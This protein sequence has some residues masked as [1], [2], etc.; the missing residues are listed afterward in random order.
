[1]GN[2]SGNLTFSAKGLG[3]GSYLL[4]GAPVQITVGVPN[5]ISSYQFDSIPDTLWLDT[6]NWTSFILPID[7]FPEWGHYILFEVGGNG[8]AML[9][10]IGISSCP[11]VNFSYEDGG[12]VCTTQSGYDAEYFLNLDDGDS[13]RTFHVLESPFILTDIAL[14]HTYTISWQCPYQN[15]GCLPKYIFSTP[16]LLP[17]PYCNDFDAD[18]DNIPSNW[19]FVN[20]TTSSY[21]Q[22]DYW[23]TSLY[24]HTYSNRW[25]YAILPDLVLDSSLSIKINISSSSEGSFE[26]GYLSNLAQATHQV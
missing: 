21:I 9:D 7:E 13:V 8:G 15:S 3:E 20:P 25:Q 24:L 16:N 4:V 17:L 2:A 26:L 14:G 19:R 22:Y 11:I 5:I 18:G 10:N 12:L 6:A 1:M 23:N